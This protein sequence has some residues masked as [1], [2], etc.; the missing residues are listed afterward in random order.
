MIK[1]TTEGPW[2]LALEF[3]WFRSTLV[4]INYIRYFTRL[5][6]LIFTV[7]WLKK[8]YKVFVIRSISLLTCNLGLPYL[9]HTFDH[10]G[11]MS[12]SDSDPINTSTD[13]K[14][15]LNQFYMIRSVSL[16]PCIL[17][18]TIFVWSTNWSW[19]VH[20]HVAW[21]CLLFHGLLTLLNL[22]QFFV[23]RSVFLMP[24]NIGLSNLV[25][26]LMMDGKKGRIYSVYR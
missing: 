11:Y 19:R 18:N 2:I 24:F 21:P 4:W 3:H 1:Y 13:F 10:E 7:Y 8:M 6:N 17:G 5:F 25:H 15:K 16:I 12:T 23:I 9:V 26:T 22:L 20:V 14:K